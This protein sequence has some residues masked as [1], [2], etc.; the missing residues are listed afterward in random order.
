MSDTVTQSGEKQYT[1]HPLKKKD[2]RVVAAM[3]GKLADEFDEPAIR[4]IIS[5]GFSDDEGKADKETADDRKARLVHV[6]FELFRKCLTKL[7]VDAE[8]WLASL[9]GVSVEEYQELPIDIDVQILNQVKEAPEVER[10]FTGALRLFSATQA[11]DKAL[12]QL[13]SS[14]ASAFGSQQESSTD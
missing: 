14:Y 6:F 2:Q 11:L 3:F 7:A 4:R 5:S 9:I 13:K 1:I 12:S 10:F 8:E